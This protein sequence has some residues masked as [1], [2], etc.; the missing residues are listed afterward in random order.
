[1]K[2]FKESE[3]QC[4]CGCGMGFESIDKQ[5]LGDLEAARDFAD[6]PFVITSSIRCL[7]H[8]AAIGGKKNSSHLKGLAFDIACKDATQRYDIITALLMN[9][10]RL[11][12]YDKFIHVDNDMTKPAGVIW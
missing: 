5:A 4:P 6:V 1:M 7:K 3:F 2:H 12:V 8:N 11:G 10:D 9:F